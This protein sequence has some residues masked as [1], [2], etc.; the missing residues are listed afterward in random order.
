MINNTIEDSLVI[1]L[2]LRL[3]DL[4]FHIYNIKLYLIVNKM[5]LILHN[6][7]V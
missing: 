7:H 4:L 5:L 3:I 6:S 1:Q 2:R